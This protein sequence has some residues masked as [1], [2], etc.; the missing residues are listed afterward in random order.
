[1]QAVSGGYRTISGGAE[2]F[3]SDA[4]TNRRVGWGV[5]AVNDVATAGTV[6]AFAYCVRS[7]GDQAATRPA[8]ARRRA[9]ARQAARA[10]VDRYRTVRAAQF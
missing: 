8:L 9:A 7:D 4:L 5:G 1:M 6:Q 10:L 2:T 3:Y